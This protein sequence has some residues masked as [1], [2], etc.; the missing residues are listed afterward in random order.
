MSKPFPLP[1]GVRQGSTL[2]PM[3][4][5]IV[6]ETLAIVVKGDKNIRRVCTPSTNHKLL[7]YANDVA[8][9]LQDPINSLRVLAPVLDSFC[10]SLKV[11]DE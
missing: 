10:S 2:S 4:S 11:Q 1:R 3:L 8:F 9:T 5:D 7:L 6:I